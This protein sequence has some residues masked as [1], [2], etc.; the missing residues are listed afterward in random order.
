MVGVDL[1]Q[2]I[3]IDPCAENI[4]YRIGQFNVDLATIRGQR[5]PVADEGQTVCPV[6]SG[7]DIGYIR[8]AADHSERLADGETQPVTALK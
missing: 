2:D 3:E 1:M 6:I 5:N 7:S 8:M 4:G